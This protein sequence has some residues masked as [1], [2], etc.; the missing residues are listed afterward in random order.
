MPG[1]EYEIWH[2]RHDFWLLA[3]KEDEEEFRLILICMYG[4]E[5][6]FAG[7]PLGPVYAQDDV[8]SLE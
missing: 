1:R 8:C 6:P 3:G 7:F 5:M 4:N 2:R